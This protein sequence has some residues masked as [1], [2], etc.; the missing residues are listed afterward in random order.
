MNDTGT[1]IEDRH[2]GE[3]LVL[4]VQRIVEPR[5]LGPVVGAAAV[6]IALF[7]IHQISGKVHLHQIEAALAATSFATVAPALAFTFVSL[8]AMACYDVMAVRRVVPGKVQARLALLA[9]FAGYGFSNAIGFHVFVGGPVRYRIYQSAGV[10][11]AD[12]GRIVGI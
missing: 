4:F 5:V 6:A 9:G 2:I 10:D 8:V 7:V 12:V 1:S 3:G 11:A